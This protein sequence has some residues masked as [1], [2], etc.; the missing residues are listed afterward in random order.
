VLFA[1][2]PSQRRAQAQKRALSVDVDQLRRRLAELSTGTAELFDAA[3]RRIDQTGREAVRSS[4]ARR[5][6]DDR[7]WSTLEP[8]A[9]GNADFEE[10]GRVVRLGETAVANVGVGLREVDGGGRHG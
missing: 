9:G 3:A 4:R 10:L 8:M 2:R 5:E 7:W 6:I 1:L